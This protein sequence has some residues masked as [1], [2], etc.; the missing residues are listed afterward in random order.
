LF[1][2]FGHANETGSLMVCLLPVMIAIAVASGRAARLLWFGA[3]AVTLSVL[4]LTVSRGAFV[5]LF[6]GCA[7]GTYICRRFVPLSRVV[8][9]GVIGLTALIVVTGLLSLA[10]PQVGALLASRF[11]GQSTVLD[12]GEASSGRTDIWAEVVNRMTD[13]PVS[14]VTGFGWDTYDSMPFYY[15]THNQ[16]LDQ[17]FNL[18]LI[19]VAALVII[20][21]Y[22]IGY[23]RRAVDVASGS[24]RG[25]MIAFL[26]GMPSL[27][28]AIFFAN[29]TKPWPYV[30]I[31][32]ALT[33][34][35]AVFVRD[36]A[37]RSAPVQV[38]VAPAP[39]LV[40]HATSPGIV[41]PLASR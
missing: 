20:L 5:G 18:G 24:M 15:V 38:Q 26:F 41:R 13:T 19:G 11:L 9:V 32:T 39:Q 3:A 6:L 2:A 17:W 4:I 40:R 35:A 7:I 28:V 1:G 8:A 10:L 31:Y 12:V 33:L 22:S 34:R 25:Y 37:E 30:W 29:L 16:Y 36:A 23:V 27:A 14:M 21:G